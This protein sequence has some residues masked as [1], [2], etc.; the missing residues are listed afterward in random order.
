MNQVLEFLAE[1]YIYV[2]GGSAVI[3]VVL[4]LI[5]AFTGKKGKKKDVPA[6]PVVGNMGM[7]VSDASALQPQPISELEPVMES[8]PM[9][10]EPVAVEEP[11]VPVME[12]VMESTPIAIEPVAEEPVVPVMEPVMESTPEEEP[13]IIPNVVPNV[14]VDANKEDET[15]TETLEVFGVE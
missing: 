3:I 9:A 2:A 4:L 10:A 8:A 6:Q 13:L 5:I 12:P 1:N 11:V 15:K 14:G 7:S